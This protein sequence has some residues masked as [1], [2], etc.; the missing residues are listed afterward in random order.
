MA[1]EVI[2]IDGMK[3]QKKK[4]VESIMFQLTQMEEKDTRSNLESLL[5]KSEP[6]HFKAL[7]WYKG[8]PVK[9]DDMEYDSAI[10]D[11]KESYDIPLNNLIDKGMFEVLKGNPSVKRGNLCVKID[12]ISPFIK[13]NIRHYHVQW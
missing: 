9:I 12:V 11:V 3:G 4:Y 5:E 6:Y 1:V 8:M 2:E 13:K 10:V 7:E